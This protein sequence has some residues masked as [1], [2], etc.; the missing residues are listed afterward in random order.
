M[1]T[2]LALAR[3][4]WAPIVA[5]A[6]LACA[7]AVGVNL[8]LPKTY[9]SEARVLV[10]QTDSAVQVYGTGI[11]Q[12]AVQKDN[13]VQTEA[14][15][16]R[17]PS[18][19]QAVITRLGLHETV[20]SLGS[21]V[22]IAPVDQTA[23][24]SIKVR[25]QDRQS[26]VLIANALADEYLTRYRELRQQSVAAAADVVAAEVTK[27]QSD[28]QALDAVAAK[29]GMSAS[30]ATERQIA[31][32]KLASLSQTLEQLRVSASVEQAGGTV[33]DR[34]VASQNPIG[35]GPVA[36]GGYGFAVGLLLSGA[37]VVFRDSRAPVPAVEDTGD[38][39]ATDLAEIRALPETASA[40]E[41]V[42]ARGDAAADRRHGNGT[43][44]A[45][46]DRRRVAGDRRQADRRRG[47][48]NRRVAHDLESVS[49]DLRPQDVHEIEA[50][51]NAL[52]VP[53]HKDSTGGSR[54]G[55]DA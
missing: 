35:P 38:V 21:K 10:S 31:S 15:L 27:A 54:S 18:L 39:V 42:R 44:P 14:E 37:V 13:P 28:L 47:A 17:S 16:L 51:W 11:P 49:E 40:L 20:G 32:D 48:V 53:P 26:P 45:A 52:G 50:F 23:V 19:L 46:G 6:L 24:I 36:S 29:G 12:L 43:P 33:T 2:Y 8:L 41:P 55:R 3:K 34:A 7:I 22:T 1:N 4:N 30:Q 25:A 5:S 9:E